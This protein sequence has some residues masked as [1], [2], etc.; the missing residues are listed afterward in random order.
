MG[1]ISGNSADIMSKA[2]A[3]DLRKTSGNVLL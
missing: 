2:L 3:S 1:K